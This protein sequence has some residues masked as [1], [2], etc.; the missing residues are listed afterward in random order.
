MQQ[1]L[2]HML[3][4]MQESHLHSK[5]SPWEGG[6]RPHRQDHHMAF[7][8]SKLLHY[9]LMP[10]FS[11]G[12]WR[13]EGGHSLVQSEPGLLRK[14]TL[15]Q[16][17]K[18][19]WMYWGKCVNKM[20]QPLQIF[21]WSSDWRRKDFKQQPEMYTSLQKVN[22][23]DRTFDNQCKGPDFFWH[24][25]RP[26]YNQW[27]LF[28]PFLLQRQNLQLKNKNISH[29]GKNLECLFGTHLWFLC[30]AF[31]IALAVK[32]ITFLT[33]IN[34]ARNIKPQQG[35][36][37]S[38]TN[39]DAKK[40]N[41]SI[42]S[43][44]DTCTENWISVRKWIQRQY[45]LALGRNKQTSTHQKIMFLVKFSCHSKAIVKCTSGLVNN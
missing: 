11:L 36:N 23:T 38:L 35:R 13:C 10:L 16:R 15:T 24:L 9:L 41:Y 22:S 33:N 18:Q 25:C 17:E 3:R 45:S 42:I 8:P 21:L 31:P 20:K 1:P 7:P 40:L 26:N 30:F 12:S 6:T 34:I 28:P 44:P 27:R 2:S 37:D 39:L 4:S 19:K 32:S 14:E 29:L 43:V 5:I